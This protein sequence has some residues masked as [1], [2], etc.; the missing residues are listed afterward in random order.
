M[1]KDFII[2]NGLASGVLWTMILYY[3]AAI[4]K[5]SFQLSGG[6]GFCLS[7]ASKASCQHALPDIVRILTP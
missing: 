2:S 1:Q 7:K 3:S 5:F 4:D 6:L